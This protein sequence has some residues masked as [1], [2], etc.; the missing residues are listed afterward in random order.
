MITTELGP[1]RQAK[2]LA[3]KL[4]EEGILVDETLAQ[5]WLDVNNKG[6]RHFKPVKLALYTR[7]M[8]NGAWKDNGDPMYFDEKGYLFEGQHRLKALVEANRQRRAA[9]LPPISLRFFVFTA[10]KETR[11]VTGSGAPRTF[12]DRQIIGGGVPF[13]GNI[14]AVG[15]RIFNWQC[16]V[17]I[18]TTSTR[19][20][21]SE[22]EFAEFYQ[23]NMK[24]IHGA[25]YWGGHLANGIGIHMMGAGL[26]HYVI[27]TAAQ[28]HF[29]ETGVDVAHLFFNGLSSGAELSAGHPALT[30]RNTIQRRRRDHELRN[31]HESLS[32]LLAAWNAYAEERK[33]FSAT[34]PTGTVV[35]SANL[36]LPVAPNANWTGDVYRDASGR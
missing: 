21:L 30:L 9:G 17:L 24:A 23:R 26:G 28:D 15:K 31:Q 27:T 19:R 4:E 29:E 1:V 13:A 11:L 10:N 36:P 5:E 14:V 34:L 3:Q 33:Y 32:L 35:T 12:N 16:G 25:A 6:N 18:P 7:D 20:N 22:I 8:Y 2:S